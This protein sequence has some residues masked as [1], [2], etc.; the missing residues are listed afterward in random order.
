MN[1]DN[2][3]N[4]PLLK[5]TEQIVKDAPG[6]F[7]KVADKCM[8]AIESGC[9]AA[10]A[11]VKGGLQS[12]FDTVSNIAK[13]ASKGMESPSQEQSLSLGKDGVA[14][15]SQAVEKTVAPPEQKIAQD[16]NLN[17][18]FNFACAEVSASNICNLTASNGV[19]HAH[20]QTQNHGM[21]V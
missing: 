12:G 14:G 21:S 10:V 18:Q 16:L 17:G 2:I 3:D 15:P 4:L 1:P 13:P 9:S 7:L 19:D 11:S 6:T 5:L 20:V 8:G